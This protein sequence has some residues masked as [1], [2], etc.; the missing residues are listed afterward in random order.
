M[1]ST[2]V[3]LDLETTGLNPKLDK[4]IEVGA[5]KVVNGKVEDTFSAFV[6]PGRELSDTVKDITGISQEEIEGAPVVG[7]I[8]P[9][10][11]DFIGDNNLLGHRIL[12]DYSFV[13][14]AAVNNGLV[15]EKKGVD[16]LKL[17]RKY[18]PELESRRLGNLCAYFKIPHQ[19]HR[20]LGDAMATHLLFEKLL[21]TF[22]E[23]QDVKPEP[24]LYNPK[25]EGP[26][27]KKQKEWLHELIAK[28][29]L[30][31]GVDVEK[32]TKNEASRLIDQILAKF[33]R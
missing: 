8:M 22:A 6:N 21:E 1:F 18:L 14:K 19:A 16:T 15:F 25:K 13:K 26:A 4:I 10:L 5:V 9:A 23:I 33:G 24:L 32:L 30:N 29:S 2:Y 12:F 31:P 7:E 20:A 17:S 11:L 27:S 3:S 28:Y